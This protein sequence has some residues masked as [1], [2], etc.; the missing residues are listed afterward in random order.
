MK[1]QCLE[2][3]THSDIRMYFCGGQSIVPFIDRNGKN[4]IALIN[5]V[6]DGMV[7][8]QPV[9][10]S[11]LELSPRTFRKNVNNFG[12]VS[13]LVSKYLINKEGRLF[14]ISPVGNQTVEKA[15]GRANTLL[16]ECVT[17]H[18]SETRVSHYQLYYD[19]YF[20]DFTQKS[21][22]Y[23]D[24]AVLSDHVAISKKTLFIFGVAAGQF[25]S[26]EELKTLLGELK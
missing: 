26:D 5:N 24:T 21:Y 25:E 15:L 1:L 11:N 18:I 2:D 16:V 3:Y 14:Y 22:R 9:T 10:L 12:E 23:E 6:E 20:T 13:K 17:G 4:R 19:Y 8:Y 7:E